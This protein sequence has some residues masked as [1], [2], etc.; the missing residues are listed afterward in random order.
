[1]SAR[2]QIIKHSSLTEDGGARSRE[3][4]GIRVFRASEVVQLENEILVKE[5]F[6]FPDNPSETTV[7]RSTGIS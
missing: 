6:V 5:L 2:H 3:I 7:V 4:E 1:M